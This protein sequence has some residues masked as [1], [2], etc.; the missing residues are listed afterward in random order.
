MISVKSEAKITMGFTDLK[1]LETDHITCGFICSCMTMVNMK[2]HAIW[3][4]IVTADN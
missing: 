2:E 4:N 1:H 3:H